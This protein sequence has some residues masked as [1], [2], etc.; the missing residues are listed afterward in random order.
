MDDDEQRD[1]RLSL[2][3]KTS[4]QQT[5][6]EAVLTIWQEADGMTALVPP[7][8]PGLTRISRRIR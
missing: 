3:I 2:R 7:H 4:P 8:E 1:G 6:Y 5:A